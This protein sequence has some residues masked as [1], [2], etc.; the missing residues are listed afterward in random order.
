MAFS[1][2]RIHK[3]AR[4]LRLFSRI[5][6]NILNSVVSSIE[7]RAIRKYCVNLFSHSRFSQI[8]QI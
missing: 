6:S 7:F 3:F 2:L 8:R 5:W 1:V 4:V